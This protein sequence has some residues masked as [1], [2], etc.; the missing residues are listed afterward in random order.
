MKRE[1]EAEDT[2]KEALAIDP[3]NAEAQEGMRKA[4]MQRY[5]AQ[6]N[7]SREERAREAQKD[8]EIQAILADPVMRQILQ[9]MQ[10]NPASAQDHLKN[11]AILEKIQKLIQSGILE[12]G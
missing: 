3:N 4:Q 7:M 1:R 11:P 2:Y 9:Q 12:M 6:A 8:P 10:E 5:G